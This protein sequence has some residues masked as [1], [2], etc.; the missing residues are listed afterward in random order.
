MT[1]EDVAAAEA[2]HIDDL[3]VDL[4]LLD[5][6]PQLHRLHYDVVSNGVL[7]FVLHDLFDTVRRPRFDIRFREAWDAYVAVNDAFAERDATPRPAKATIVLVQ[8]YQ[9]ALVARAAARAAARICGSCTSR[10]RRSAAPTAS[11]LLPTDVAE[12]LCGSLGRRAGGVPHQSLGRVVRRRDAR[13]PRRPGRD[14]S[15]SRRASVPTCDALTEMAAEPAT[16]EAADALADVVG[17]R[18]VIVRIRPGRAVEEHRARLPRLRPSA[19]SAARPA[20]ARRVRRD[21]VSVAPGASRVPRVRERDRA[22]GRSCER[23]LGD[24]RLAPDRARPPRRLRPLRCRDAALRRALREP[25][26]GRHEP[27]RQRRSAPQPARRVVVPVTRSGRV[28]RVA[29]R[30]ASRCTR[31]TSSRWR[32]RSTT[33]SR[34]RSTIEPIA[35]RRLRELAAATSPTTWLNDLLAQAR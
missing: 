29:V 17:D 1:R 4:H 33:R 12:S 5:L 3:G 22:G 34:R 23:A 32:A 16:R 25:A 7:W 13:S 30:R 6:D 2:G 21:G 24:A 27:R 9:L 10:T 28:R 26:Q 35:A 20:R 31:S 18:L 14:R 8:D 15:R 19:R 11:A